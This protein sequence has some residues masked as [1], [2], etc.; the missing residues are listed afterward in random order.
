MYITVDN[1]IETISE[2]SPQQLRI[3]YGAVAAIKNSQEIAINLRKPLP[4]AS[5]LSPDMFYREG[6]DIITHLIKVYGP[7]GF[8]VLDGYSMHRGDLKSID[9]PAYWRLVNLE[10]K[11][12]RLPA[13]ILD[14][15]TKPEACARYDELCDE[16]GL[17]DTATTASRKRARKCR[18][19]RGPQ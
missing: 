5:D 19:S 15:P 18:P 16:Y 9:E 13:D 17:A 12:G 11:V 14:L 4:K 2:L 10:R 6:D 3:A 7:D 1:L 8:D